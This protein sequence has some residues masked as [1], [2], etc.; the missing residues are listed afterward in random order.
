[1]DRLCLLWHLRRISHRTHHQNHGHI[2]KDESWHPVSSTLIVQ[3][4]T[5][6]HYCNSDSELLDHLTDICRQMFMLILSYSYVYILLVGS[7]KFVRE[8]GRFE[9]KGEKGQAN[10]A[11]SSAWDAECTCS[12]A[13]KGGN[14]SI[15]LGCQ[16]KP[17][18][19]I[20][21]SIQAKAS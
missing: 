15:W 19:K 14:T 4:T 20:H 3:N 5:R 16:T 17:P 6:Q 7:T 10:I 9:V 21:S 11:F 8:F 2:D 13:G 1:M 12:G 18:L